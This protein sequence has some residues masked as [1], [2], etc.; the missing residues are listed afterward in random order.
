MVANTVRYTKE[1]MEEREKICNG[2]MKASYLML[3]FI[4]LI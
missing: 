3:L 4:I 2:W 1:C